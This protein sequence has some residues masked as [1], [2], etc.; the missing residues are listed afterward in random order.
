[1]AANTSLEV[2]HQPC[3]ELLTLAFWEKGL[4][5]PLYIAAFVA[6]RC[7][8]QHRSLKTPIRMWQ[9]AVVLAVLAIIHASIYFSGTYIEQAGDAPATSKLASFLIRSV[10]LGLVPA[11]FCFR[12]G[13]SGWNGA[14]ADVC[15][16]CGIPLIVFI[17][18]TIRRSRSS[19]WA[20]IFCGVTIIGNRV[21]L[22]RGRVALFG[23]DIGYDFRYQFDSLL[24]LAAAAFAISTNPSRVRVRTTD[25]AVVVAP[26]VLRRPVFVASLAAGA[27][28]V[29]GSIPTISSC[30]QFNLGQ[31]AGKY[32]SSSRSSAHA[33]TAK[34][35]QWTL[36]DSYVR[37]PDIPPA[38]FPYNLWSVSGPLFSRDLRIATTTQNLYTVGPTG[39]LT[40]ADFDVQ[41]V[42]EPSGEMAL[43]DRARMAA[44]VF[45]LPV[46]FDRVSTD[47]R[48]LLIHFEPADHRRSLVVINAA[49]GAAP[50]VTRRG[51]PSVM[52][53]GQDQLLISVHRSLSVRSLCSPSARRRHVSRVWN[54]D[55]SYGPRRD[56][57]R[58]CREV[59][60][61]SRPR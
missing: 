8:A 9:P 32:F 2:P 3:R 42:A 60:V 12:H 37:S 41:S 16:L 52:P 30:W 44:A 34:G 22:G 10:T 29:I 39:A 4:L 54:W 46:G 26:G 11:S 33:V 21:V 53:T 55:L 48:Y 28:F 15:A 59:Q 49:K 40:A 61:A 56:D 36:V 31:S 58:S 18:F 57:Q 14:W 47:G 23:V 1:M 13:G 43:C 35:T 27:L 6:A 7:L 51:R 38:F 5:V 50:D 25:W 19:V 17:V 24:L 20:W 45:Q